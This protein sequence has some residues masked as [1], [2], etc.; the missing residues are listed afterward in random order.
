VIVNAGFH[1]TK[2]IK[3]PANIYLLN[4]PKSNPE[5][6]PCEQV[7]QYI[8]NSFKNQRFETMQELRQSLH[9]MVNSMD[10]ETAKSIT[11]NYH[12]LNPFNTAFK[13]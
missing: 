5:L 2:N 10:R 7:W 9:N 6:N 8:K 13:N 3:V 12:H 4:I 1:S 11:G